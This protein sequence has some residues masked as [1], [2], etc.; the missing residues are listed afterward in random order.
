MYKTKYLK[1]KKK[2]VN[3]KNNKYGG[4]LKSPVGNTIDQ[5]KEEKFIIYKGWRVDDIWKLRLGTMSDK[6]EN[7]KTFIEDRFEREYDFDFFYEKH[8]EIEKSF[9]DEYEKAIDDADRDNN[10][11]LKKSL[12]LEKKKKIGE[13]EKKYKKN[14][15][16]S[17][18]TK[19]FNKLINQQMLFHNNAASYKY[20]LQLN[21][22]KDILEKESKNIYVDYSDY[23]NNEYNY[24]DYEEIYSG[25]YD[26]YFITIIQIS[27]NFIRDTENKDPNF[28]RKVFWKTDI[29]P[30]SVNENDKIYCIQLRKNGI[31]MLL[32][33]HSRG[34][35]LK[36]ILEDDIIKKKLSLYLKEEIINEILEDD[37]N[38]IQE[39]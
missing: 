6:F 20:S 14:F 19:N 34:F 35:D 18:I 31:N 17:Y 32:K 15:E 4:A 3:L 7:L 37:I 39:E 12:E 1:Y 9:E 22:Y 21:Q 27:Y 23:Y 26:D 29:V 11:E 28:L 2:Y 25:Y 13:E 16:E 24:N 30:Y 5:F 8:K 10:Y 38:R 36:Q 33:I